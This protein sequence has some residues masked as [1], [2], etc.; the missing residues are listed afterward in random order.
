MSLPREFS[1]IRRYFAPLAGPGALDLTDDAAVI[2]PPAGRD[3]VVTA[4]TMVQ[5]VHYLPDELPE[6]VARKL[7][8]VNLSDIAAMGA[9]PLGYL[10]T[11]S[12]PR[13]TPDAWFESFAKGLAADQARYNI[14]LLGG[15]TTSTPGPVSL[16]VMM[17]GHVAH[18]AALRR[19][20]AEAGDDLWVTGT[21][22]NGVLGLRALR[23]EIPD[24]D[25]TLAAH[26]RFPEPRL[27][28]A[29]QGIAH[30]AMDIS[31]GLLQDSGHMARA[32]G[33]ALTLDISRVPL[34]PAGKAAGPDFVS[35]GTAGGD[36]YELLL[37]VP[38]SQEPALRAAA[39]S[40]EIIVNKIGWFDAG[41]PSVV[42]IDA[43]GRRLAAGGGGWSHL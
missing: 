28:L 23:G 3:L 17:F 25:G 29:L 2:T 6:N 15:D 31:D 1:I 5:G 10:L 16:S 36:D 13:G 22:G 8:R 18:G 19:G 20:G 43:E 33:L 12:V 41:E 38:P 14:S 27:G 30:A 11:L 4:D 42:L 37:A 34:S 39:R 35:S 40:C 21:I 26:Y 7:L 9:I 32:S 24:P